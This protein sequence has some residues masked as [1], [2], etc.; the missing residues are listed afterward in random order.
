MM[1]STEERTGKMTPL[2]KIIHTRTGKVVKAGMSEKRC[3]QWF[4]RNDPNYIAYHHVQ[5]G[6]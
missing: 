6:K 3:D 4:K 2:C 5:G 1:Q